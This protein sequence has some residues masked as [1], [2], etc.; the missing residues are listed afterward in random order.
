[1]ND[2]SRLRPRGKGARPVASAENTG[3]IVGAAQVTAQKIHKFYKVR[4]RNNPLD[5]EQLRR[6]ELQARMSYGRIKRHRQGRLALLG[7][8][9]GWAMARLNQTRAMRSLNLFFFHYGTVMAA[10]AAYMMFFSVAAQIGRASC[11]ERGGG[12]ARAR[13]V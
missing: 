4:P 5:A 1:M 7:A 3:G 2:P 11:R 12:S 9:I 6:E 10:G 13:C 8:W